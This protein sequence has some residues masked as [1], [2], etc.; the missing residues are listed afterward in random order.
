MNFSVTCREGQELV[1]LLIKGST[2]V[3]EIKAWKAKHSKVKHL[4]HVSIEDN[5]DKS[6]DEENEAIV[7]KAW[8]RGFCRCHKNKLS[9]KKAVCCDSL[10]DD[11]CTLH[12]FEVMYDKIFVCMVD[13]SVAIEWGDGQHWV[14][15]EGENATCEEDAYGR[16]T[17]F[18]LIHP[19]K[20]IFVDEVG[21]NMSQKNDGNIGGEK[22]LVY[23]DSVAKICSAFEDCHF[24]VLRFTAAHVDRFCVQSHWYIKF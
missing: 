10:H 16:K 9:A 19:E 1:Q 2:V 14:H 13:C 3:E 11:W 17:T 6:E 8:W 18:S 4:P 15:H 12:N 21:C 5:D 20:V 22:F 24:T 23:P 7:G